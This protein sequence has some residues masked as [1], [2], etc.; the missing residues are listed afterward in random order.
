MDSLA[1]SL[2]PLSLLVSADNLHSETGDTLY[3]LP[4]VRSGASEADAAKAVMPVLQ[5]L[6]I[7]ATFSGQLDE[8]L[9]TLYTQGDKNP[10]GAT[11]A[12]VSN[13]TD[14]RVVY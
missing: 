3:R 5:Q 14:M 4:P 9:Q 11:L 12:H 2:E 1:K 13:R 10:E 7:A 8:S 6:H